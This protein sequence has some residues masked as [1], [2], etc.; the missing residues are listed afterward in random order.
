LKIGSFIAGSNV[1]GTLVDTDRVA[2]LCHENS[3]LAFFDY[4]AVAPYIEISVSGPAKHRYFDYDLTG[5]EALCYKDAVFISPHKFVGGPGTTGLLIAK[6][7]LMYDT[8]P[9]RPAGGT[10]LFVNEKEHVYL[11]NIEELEEGGTPGIL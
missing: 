8:T 11:G 7:E 3:T 10:V 5:K 2:I 6:R 1:T 4:A 9:A